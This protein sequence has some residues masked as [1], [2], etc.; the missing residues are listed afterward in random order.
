MVE[1]HFSRYWKHPKV[2]VS[3]QW[4]YLKLYIIILFYAFNS[5]MSQFFTKIIIENGVVAGI[6]DVFKSSQ[7]AVWRDKYVT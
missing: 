5:Y 6:C 7:R 3:Q 2:Y 4:W 1:E